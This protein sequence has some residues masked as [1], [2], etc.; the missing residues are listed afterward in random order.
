M[1]PASLVGL[2]LGA[3]A[4]LLGVFAPATAAKITLYPTPTPGSDPF[5]MTTTNAV[6]FT[7]SQAD[8]LGRIDQSGKIT[9]IA[10]PTGSDPPSLTPTAFGTLAVA[11]HGT[12]SIDEVATDGTDTTHPIPDG[13]KPYAVTLGSDSGVWFSA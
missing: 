9:E 8:K 11:E 1:K 7:E 5:G 13:L 4:L 12:A 2:L 10:L 6:W 3:F